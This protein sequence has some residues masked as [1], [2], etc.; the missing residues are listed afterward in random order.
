MKKGFVFISIGIVCLLFAI[1]SFRLYS[2][3]ESENRVKLTVWTLQMNDYS[4][5][6]NRIIKEYETE[7]P[8]VKIDWID[9]PFSEGEKRTLAAVLTDCPPDLVNLNPDFSS[10][11]AQK[12]VLEEIPE[13]KLEGFNSEI[14]NT[15]KYY[16]KLYLIPWYATSAVTIY[17]KE[18]FEKAG[19]NPPLNYDDYLKSS[20]MITAKT[21]KYM[22]LIPLTENDTTVKILNKYGLNNYE[23]VKSQTSV[24]LFEMF[25]KM[26]QNKLLPPETI[27]Q[28]HREALEKYMSGEIAMLQAGAN[29]LNMI[30]DNAPDVY[31]NT[32]VAPQA[33]GSL[34]Q[35][36][37]SLMNFVIPKNSKNKE[38]ALDFCLFLTNDKN[39]LELAKMTNIL[40]TRNNVLKDNFYNDEST[41]TSKAR[42]I[43]A[44]QLFNLKPVLKQ[45]QN[46]KEIN[47]LV[48]STVQIILLNKVSTES[49]LK[50]LSQDWKNFVKDND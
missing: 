30:K 17:N 37:F 42:K 46:Q 3:N 20:E 43:S 9:I 48:N 45:N 27:T 7:N 49:A 29:F 2:A 15:S 21:N 31:K 4:D 1:F 19:L 34:G 6:F 32:D 47:N 36:D 41:L 39:Q 13:D 22:T 35:N 12:G 40:A 24:Q 26:Y 14:L 8:N 11:L 10:I 28:T 38:L 33:K 25:K 18:I 50:K 5:Y 44:T 23:N 16:G